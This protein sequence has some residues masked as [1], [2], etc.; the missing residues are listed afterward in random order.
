MPDQ[1]T[2]SLSGLQHLANFLSENGYNVTEINSKKEGEDT[3]IQSG[4]A[5]DETDANTATQNNNDH[6][7]NTTT[8]NSSGDGDNRHTIDKPNI[9]NFVLGTPTTISNAENDELT[10][11]KIM[12]MTPEQIQENMPKI[13]AHILS[14]GGSF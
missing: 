5:S 10:E 9:L 12:L 2:V 6:I 11:D 8:S 4:K 13:R 1:E 3:T 14:N 7:D